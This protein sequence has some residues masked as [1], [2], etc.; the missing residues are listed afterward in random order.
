VKIAGLIDT[1]K[2]YLYC[3]KPF[4]IGKISENA[5]KVK[6]PVIFKLDLL[7]GTTIKS[8]LRE[9]NFTMVEMIFTKEEY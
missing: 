2:G 1:S 3:V 5:P 4:E 7:D 9:R 6:Y 8:E